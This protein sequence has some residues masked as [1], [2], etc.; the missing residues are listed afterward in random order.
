MTEATTRDFG[1]VGIL[2][3]TGPQGRGLA[4]RLAQAGVSVVLGSR[5]AARATEIATT[6]G[7]G[8]LG[9][10][11][12]TCARD[13][14]MVIVAVP[15]D[16]HGALLTSL[17]PSLQNKIVIDCVNPLGFDK[18]GP[19][20]LAVAAGSACEQAQSL[21]PDSVVVGAFHHLS[22]EL[23]EDPQVVSIDADVLVLGDD[24]DATDTVQALAEQI[25]GIR[26]MYAG[27]LRNAHQVEAFTA[28]LIAIN[29]RYKTHSGVRIA[30][31]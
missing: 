23:L 25:P 21:L 22:A 10:D 1:T 19:Y 14:D 20:A 17:A 24:R 28:N 11:N 15:W 30:G 13:S 12:D 4:V 2:G 16:G 7:H 9:A 3:G 27:R 31:V 5:D 29:R 8:I 18:Q 6:L 26:G